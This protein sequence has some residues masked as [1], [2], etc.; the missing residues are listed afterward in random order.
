MQ[1]VS[2]KSQHIP[3]LTDWYEG[4][5][6]VGRKSLWHHYTVNK[7]H[8]RPMNCQCHIIF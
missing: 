7:R 3:A 1:V 5:K 4:V 8:V 2:S 6:D